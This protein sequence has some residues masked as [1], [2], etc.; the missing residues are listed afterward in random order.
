MILI[1]LLVPL[2]V[3][4]Q[5]QDP[6]STAA[7]Q[8]IATAS[9]ENVGEQGA[10]AL[11][12][13]DESMAEYRR[14]SS[15]LTSASRED[16]LVIGLQMLRHEDRFMADMVDLARLLSTV[17]DDPSQQE[18]L[19]RGEL[20]FVSM[21]A[22]LWEL[23]DQRRTQIDLKRALRTETPPAEKAALENDLALLTR[24][25]DI[26]YSY[27]LDHI[28]R[29]ESFGLETTVARDTLAILLEENGRRR[30]RAGWTWPRCA[31]GSWMRG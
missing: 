9:A 4:A 6:D 10:E 30:C 29:M 11:R 5:A 8:A 23:I 20:V 7:V 24:R 28:K 1:L 25:L 27:G 18:L 2:G 17:K 13:L 21:T 3:M 19:A 12:R 26:F 14:I 15:K 22:R 16:S 31:S